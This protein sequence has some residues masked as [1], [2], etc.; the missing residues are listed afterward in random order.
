MER[1]REEGMREAERM[2]RQQERE[3]KEME[4]MKR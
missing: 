1:G 2:G 4:K 3:G